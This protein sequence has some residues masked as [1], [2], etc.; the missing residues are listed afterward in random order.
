MQLTLDEAVELALS[1]NP[2]IKIADLEVRRY[3]YV[4]RETWGNWI[5]QISV[6]GTYTRSIVKRE[7]A[8]GLSFGAD[9]TLTATGDATWAFFAPQIF[10]TLKLNRTH[11]WRP[12]WRR[13]AA[14]ASRWWPT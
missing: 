3:D 6:G 10:R 9:N 12:P 1:E 11:R 14:R 7:M 5:P 8:K 4:R 2:T 13:P